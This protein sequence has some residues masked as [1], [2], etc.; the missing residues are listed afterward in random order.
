MWAE[1]WS[2]VERADG[3]LLDTN[4]LLLAVVYRIDPAHVPRFKRTN[5]F[6]PNDGEVLRLLIAPARALVTT[7]HVLAE[8]YNL[9][10]QLDERRKTAA[11]ALLAEL[12][13]MLDERWL[14]AES[15]IHG[16]ESS[17]IARR[18]GLT[19][20]ALVRLSMQ[21]IV[22]LTAD[23]LLANSVYEM[24]GDVVNFNYYRGL[25]D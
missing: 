20:A 9:L 11:W 8:T 18:L 2:Q 25:E 10:G 16:E 7:P 15:V 12:V 4:V 23:A 24:G 1:A 6:V 19:D 17:G 5:Q 22:V 14:T 21:R 13:R 3:V